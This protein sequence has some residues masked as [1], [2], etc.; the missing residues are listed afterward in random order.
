MTSRRLLWLLPGAFVLA[1]SGEPDEAVADGSGESG[2][3]AGVPTT[4]GVE[5]SGSADSSGGG[6]SASAGSDSS[7]SGA[8]DPSTETG[9]ETD[10]TEAT[11]TGDTGGVP[12]DD[13]AGCDDLL[14]CNGVETCDAGFCAAGIAIVCDDG[15]ACTFDS[16][17]DV[18]G[19]V[20]VV[21]PDDNACSDGLFCTGA[22]SCDVVADCQPGEPIVCDDEV[23]C[24]AD[25]CSEDDDACSFTPD[26]G[27]CDNGTFCDGAEICDP[28]AGCTDPPDVVCDDLIACTADACDEDNDEC[29]HQENDG[30]CDNGVYCDGVE[31][32]TSGVGCGPGVV[33]Q[34]PGDGIACTQE[35]C[36]ENTDGCETSLDNDACNANQFCTPGGC[37]DGA[38]CDIADGGNGNPDCDDG[39]ACNGV[40]VCADI[41]GP[42]D[43]CQPGEPVVCDD[44]FT[45]TFD[46]CIEPG[47]CQYTPNDGACSDNDVCNGVEVCSVG[48]GCVDTQDL[49]CS[50]GVACTIDLCFPQVGCINAPD[51]A[52][53][54]DAVVCNGTEVCDPDLD[55]Q[56]GAPVLC[57]SDGIACTA[58]S[59]IEELGGCFAV[60]DNDLCPCGEVCNPDAGGCDDTCSPATCDGH[61]YACGNCLDDDGD[62][63]IDSA[64]SNCFGPCS[65]NEAGLDGGIPGQD[66]APCKHD[67]YFDNNSGTGDDD[68]FWNHE[69]DPL[70]PSATTCE[71]DPDANTPGTQASCDELEVM[72][73]GECD[74]VC[75]PLTP[76][77][78]DCFG[79][80]TVLLPDYGLTEVFLG[81]AVDGDGDP[82]CS[83]EVFDAPNVLDLCHP[84]TQVPACLNPC[85]P[86]EV[87]FGQELSPDCGGEQV[88]PDDGQACGQPGQ[89]PCPFGSFCLT[90]CCIEA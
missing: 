83:T 47:T 18:D 19:G 22:E 89:D 87:C 64:D 45:C 50:D 90:G 30:D 56:A 6:M 43:Q 1:C 5:S 20:C 32:C 62:C 48:Q 28:V 42:V 34:C 51:D 46:S 80:C 63:D 85:D 25:A 17:N 21:A 81:S 66:N 76:N 73:S 27:A 58:E 37:I 77:G 61:V 7:S 35:S 53:C 2:T 70:E 88:C 4:G 75:G 72:Q 57:A 55:C 41:Q 67:C 13:N 78:C 65:D 33:V 12:C 69:C 74:M 52:P 15:V 86:C 44:G 60:P 79:C 49:G 39:I 9:S 16:C 40:E 3:T 26:D 8:T 54:D 84:C 23:S 68:C 38:S 24:T 82:T 71:Y 59:C 14:P 29:A 10:P 31:Q 11:T 36:D